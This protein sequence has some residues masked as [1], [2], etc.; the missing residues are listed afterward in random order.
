MTISGLILVLLFVRIQEGIGSCWLLS[1]A[2]TKEKLPKKIKP[3]PGGKF[4]KKLS[5]P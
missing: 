5:P 3:M 2:I 1:S 4:T